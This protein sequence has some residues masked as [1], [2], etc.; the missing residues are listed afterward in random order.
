MSAQQSH[1]KGWKAG[2]PNTRLGWLALIVVTLL[3]SS[4]A[5]Y[6]MSP[7]L[8]QLFL[9]SDGGLS[10]VERL[11]LGQELNLTQTTSGLRVNVNR[12]YA[13]ANRIVVGYIVNGPTLTNNFAMSSSLTDD[14]GTAFQLSEERST[15]VKKGAR[16][17]IASFDAAGVRD[18]PGTL[19]LK[20]E[21]GQTPPPTD[22]LIERKWSS[23][24]APVSFDLRLD[25]KIDRRIV[26]L[27]E[28]AQASGITLVLEQVRI[29]PT[30]V[31]AILCDATTYTQ[32]NV[33]HWL[34]AG[35]LT[36]ESGRIDRVQS[37]A[38]AMS[39]E[40]CHTLKFPA[41]HYYNQSGNWTLTVTELTAPDHEQ[42]ND[43]Q[44]TGP[45]TFHFTAPSK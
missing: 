5:A 3:L 17:F 11:N 14:S 19:H 39:I 15:A 1:D 18:I 9:N 26:D 10:H 34:S 27:R 13:D 44:V 42:G 33:P 31:H 21:P 2:T 38:S 6:A 35:V 24:G 36:T 12:V 22:S 8:S 32:G 4:T 25:T 45:W 28:A 43:K 29:S 37:D 30:S 23:L 7:R 40:G 16:A 20:L 41:A